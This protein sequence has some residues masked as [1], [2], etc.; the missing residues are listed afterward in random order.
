M[1]KQESLVEKVRQTAV[2]KAREVADLTD[3]GIRSGAYTY[4]VKVT[5][6]RPV[7]SSGQTDSVA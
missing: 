3:A 5:P 4:P 7:G 2:S 1:A 6:R